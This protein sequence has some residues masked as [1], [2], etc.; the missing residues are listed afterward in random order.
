V[1]RILKGALELRDRRDRDQISAHGLAI[2]RGKL[3]AKMDR[4]LTWKPKHNENR[5]LLKHLVEERNALFTFLDRRGI[6]ATNHLAE[7]GIRP[8][9]VNRKVWGGNRTWMGAAA[10]ERLMSFFVTARRQ[11]QDPTALLIPVLTSPDPR[12]AGLRGLGPAPPL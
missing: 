8:A 2:A 11:D 7:Q 6:P 12:L 10:H 3:E 1:K 5:K 4:L 9:V